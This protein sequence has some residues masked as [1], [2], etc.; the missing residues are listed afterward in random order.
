MTKWARMA[1]FAIELPDRPG[2]LARLAKKFRAADVS[3]IGIWG[4][5]GK[6]QNARFYCVP[7]SADQ[8]RNFADSAGLNI[9]EGTTFY[10]S[11]SDTVGTLVRMLEEI[12]SSGVNLHAIQCVS[13]NGEF[14]CFVWA[15]PADWET[16]TRL[17]DK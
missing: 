7:E 9:T 3:L 12:A 11:G 10:L 6:G 14:G 13:F 4:Y 17:I 16:L 2:E 8:F 5:G 1:D 15:D